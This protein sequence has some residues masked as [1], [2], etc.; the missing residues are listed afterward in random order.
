MVHE[1][2]GH[3]ER[4]A[5]RAGELCAVLGISKRELRQIVQAERHGGE[6]ILSGGAGYYLPSNSVEVDACVRFLRAMARELFRTSAAIEAAAGENK[7]AN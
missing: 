3:G 5:K 6:P 1:L 4:N 7:W 2:L